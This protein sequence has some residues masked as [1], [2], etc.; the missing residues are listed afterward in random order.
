MP[1]DD[2]IT[3]AV[4]LLVEATKI[5][6]PKVTKAQPVT[7]GATRPVQVMPSGEVMIREVPVVAT[8]TNRPLPKA[9]E[10][11]GFAAAA[12]RAVQE[13]ARRGPSRVIK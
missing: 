10:D 11:Q 5:P 1:S 8:A 12:V 7:E 6:L 9:T 13:A 2:V 4:P 3:M